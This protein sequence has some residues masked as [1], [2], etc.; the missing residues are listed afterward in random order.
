MHAETEKIIF[1]N[2]APTREECVRKIIF[3]VSATHKV[4]GMRVRWYQKE[5][6]QRRIYIPR[7]LL[8]QYTILLHQPRNQKSDSNVPG[9]HFGRKS[10][11]NVPTMR[12]GPRGT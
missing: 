5:K 4:A 10:E 11:R 2:F 12:N 9:N 6:T 8:Y 1:R 3:S 7:I